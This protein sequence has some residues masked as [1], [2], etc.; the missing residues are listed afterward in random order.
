MAQYQFRADM[1]KE[2][3]LFYETVEQVRRVFLP[4]Q[5]SDVWLFLMSDMRTQFSR[6]EQPKLLKDILDQLPFIPEEERE[7]ATAFILDTLD[8]ARTNLR[9][10]N[11]KDT[12]FDL[13]R[14]K[15][16]I[17][18]A[19]LNVSQSIAEAMVPACEPSPCLLDRSRASTRSSTPDPRNG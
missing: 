19:F 3:D 2:K 13:I 16:P 8:H 7:R 15:S 5:E 18:I 12:D 14:R 4:M 6:G 11:F 9:E 10:R 1:K 17:R